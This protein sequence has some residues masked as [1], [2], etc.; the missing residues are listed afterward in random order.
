MRFGRAIAIGLAAALATGAAADAR[1]PIKPEPGNYTGKVTKGN[2]T[3]KVQLSYARFQTGGKAHLGVQLFQWTGTLK[4][5]GGPD[6]TTGG[7]VT[8]RLHGLKFHGKSKGF[9]TVSLRG[10]FTS[11]TNMRGTIKATSVQGCRTGPVKFTAKHG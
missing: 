1:K 11:A 8:A 5:S 3:G 10:R 9:L 4:C 2:G 6:Q 7:G